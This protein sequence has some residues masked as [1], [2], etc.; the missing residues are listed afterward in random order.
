MSLPLCIFTSFLS[1]LLFEISRFK[2]CHFLFSTLLSSNLASRAS[3]LSRCIRQYGEYHFG[4]DR[5]V[6][7]YD[8]LALIGSHLIFLAIV[9]C[10][11]LLLF[12]SRYEF[13]QFRVGIYLD[14]Y[15]DYLWCIISYYATMCSLFLV[16]SILSIT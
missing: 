2:D 7:D 15:H 6:L 13:G 14:A 12:V 11:C 1:S 3:F 8:N 10:Y 9:E 16:S 5:W 4:K